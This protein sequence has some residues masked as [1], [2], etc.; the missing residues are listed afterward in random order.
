MAG[1]KRADYLE[2]RKAIEEKYNEELAALDKVFAMFGGTPIS[3]RNGSGDGS[4][5]GWAHDISKRDA[6]REAVKTCTLAHF[7]LKDVRQVL[8]AAFPDRSSGISD[9]QLSAILSKLG[10]KGEINI[11]KKKAGKTP[12]VYGHKILVAAF[13]EA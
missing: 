7:S 1:M 6:V 5:R 3:D 13:K 2:M 11:V 9:N 8:D 4:K 12:A 10:E